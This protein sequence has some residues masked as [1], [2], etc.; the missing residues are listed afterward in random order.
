M[1]DLNQDF[2]GEN[3]TFVNRVEHLRARQGVTWARVAEII[4]LSR[5]MLH[6][7]RKGT[8]EPSRK[9]MIRLEQ[10]EIDAGL[11]KPVL[12]KKSVL[13]LLK[14]KPTSGIEISPADHDAGEVLIDVEYRRGSPPDGC[15]ARIPVK[16]PDAS[17]AAQL[18]VDVMLDE[19]FEGFLIHCLPADYAKREFLNKLKPFSFLKLLEAALGMSLGSRWRES[20]PHVSQQVPKPPLQNLH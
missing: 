4:G 12:E 8:N 14:S 18:L 19:D 20:F 13:E 17:I 3:N 9:T 6:L 1:V 5:T 15:P 11:R 10:A 7:I 16:A 2:F